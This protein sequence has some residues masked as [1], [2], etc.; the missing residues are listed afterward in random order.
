MEDHARPISAGA[1]SPP[2]PPDASNSARSSA[3]G[4]P[5]DPRTIREVVGLSWVP[6]YTTVL[7]T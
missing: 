6:V 3:A 4:P 5:A 2:S 1:A 7:G